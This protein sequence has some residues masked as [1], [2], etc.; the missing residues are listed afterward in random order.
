MR[1]DAIIFQ[2][3]LCIF[4]IMKLMIELITWPTVALGYMHS[5]VQF[6]HYSLEVCE[7]THAYE[8]CLSLIIQ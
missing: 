2:R 5:Q 4:T 6:L 3:F 1:S 8:I 7:L